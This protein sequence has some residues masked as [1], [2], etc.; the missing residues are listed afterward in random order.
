MRGHDLLRRTATIAGVVCLHLLV[1]FTVTRINSYRPPGAL[2][3][4]STGLDGMIPALG[5][6]W[7]FYW[8]AYPYL[9][10]GA[11]LILGAMSENDFARAIR[12]FVTITLV[13]GAVQLLYPVA[14]P[15]TSGVH[16]M[17]AALHDWAFT[18]PYAC[19]PSM[20]VA[21][22]VITSFMGFVTTR[23][24]VLRWLYVVLAAAITV[25]TLTLK[26]HYLADA[27][28]GSLLGFAGG[29]WWFVGRR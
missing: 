19:V 7:V 8:A 1:Y 26:E 20:H 3:D 15:W 6:T 11:G 17:Q 5:W 21:Y 28:T 27:V 12:A 29:L 9:T 18:R 22:S 10:V 13:G 23:A 25:S 4:P 24:T 2:K 16:P 14:A